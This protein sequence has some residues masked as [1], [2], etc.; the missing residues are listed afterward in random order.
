MMALVAVACRVVAGGLMF[1]D[2]VDD[3]AGQPGEVLRGAAR[4][5]VIGQLRALGR[6]E[7]IEADQADVVVLDGSQSVTE[8][9]TGIAA[10]QRVPGV[11]SLDGEQ[12]PR[13]AQAF[14]VAEVHGPVPLT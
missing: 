9:C 3:F 5:A 10:D 7:L 12:V 6:V 13:P 8:A 4:I 11:E 1:R 14:D 2:L